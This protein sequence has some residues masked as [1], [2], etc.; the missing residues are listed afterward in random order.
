MNGGSQHGPV[1]ATRDPRR[2]DEWGLVLTA[3]GIPF[4]L[5]VSD[6]EIRLWTL[7]GDFDRAV[8][9]LDAFDAENIPEPPRPEVPRWGSTAVGFVFAW[10]VLAAH[11][12]MSGNSRFF[13]RG[14]ARAERLLGGEPW[15]AVTALT[16]HAD[17]PHVA[18]NA[19]FGGAL[20]TA[21]AWRIG[22]GVAFALSVAA[23]VMGNVLTALLYAER[24][25]AIGA[26]T[27]VFGTLGIVSGTSLFDARRYGVRRRAPWVLIGASVALLGFLGTNEGSDVIAHATGWASGVAL[28]LAIV[29]V[30]SAPLRGSLQ[31]V[32]AGLACVVLGGAWALAWR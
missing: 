17:F 16:L 27:A 9:E 8:H 23:G 13:V 14:S 7:P 24:H 21:A 19:A 12:A 3:R 20:L 28:G 22:P 25:T 15:R 32:F 6:G 31:W 29:A 4:E 18:G 10:V 11:G 1:R 5:D 2:A 26:S 30:S